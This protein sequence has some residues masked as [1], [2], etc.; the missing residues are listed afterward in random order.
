MI[1]VAGLTVS[2]DAEPV[3]RGVSF[4][5]SAGQVLGVVG[6]NG[7]G[8]ST[9]LKAMLG[10]VPADSGT[11]AVAGRPIGEV[12][13]RVAYLPQ[14]SAIDW[15]FPALV[16][17]VAVMGRYAAVGGFRRVR[18]AD[19]RIGAAALERVGM[20][21]LAKRQIGELSGGQQQRV[22][23]ARALAQDAEVILLDE[24]FTGVD[25]L[26]QQVLTEQ[27]AALATA[28]RTVV[29]V[30]HDLSAVGRNV[31]RLL[32]LAGRVIAVGSPAEVFTGTLLTEAYGG[33]PPI[34][35]SAAA[36]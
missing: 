15:D 14:R 4:T 36:T 32:L 29:L 1:D 25:A 8:K 17:E 33:V 22:L 12:R 7:A 16:G 26:T 30:D 34:A 5:A 18:A 31:D 11:V 27:I 23:F 24:P 35:M 6:P 3:L 21:G 10:L 20:Q 13:R 28:G 9:L 19:R 2:Y